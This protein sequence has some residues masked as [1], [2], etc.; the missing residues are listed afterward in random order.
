MTY[1]RKIKKGKKKSKKNKSKKIY[2]HGR[3]SNLNKAAAAVTPPPTDIQVIEPHH[4]AITDESLCSNNI[5]QCLLF[6]I[7]KPEI[8][9]LFHQFDL[10][11]V[12]QHIEP[13]YV[14]SY[15]A[16]A[17][18]LQYIS[19][20]DDSEQRLHVILKLS[21]S[22]SSDN[23][24]YEYYVGMYINQYILPYLPVFIET[25]ELLRFIPNGYDILFQ[26]YSRQ[27]NT[28][29]EPLNMI[30][31]VEP[32]KVNF[33]EDPPVEPLN[34][35][36]TNHALLLQDIYE[37]YSFK[38]MNLMKFNAGDI[39]YFQ[40]DIP[41][42]LFQL[43]YSLDLLLRHP[44]IQFVHKDLHVENIMIYELAEYIEYHFECGAEIVQFKSKYV[45][46][47]IDYG[48]CYIADHRF[49]EYNF[50]PNGRENGFFTDESKCIRYD[51]PNKSIDLR[52]IN[53]LNNYRKRN[54]LKE[55]NPRSKVV[56]YFTEEMLSLFELTHFDGGCK[57]IS[58][59]SDP[60][61]PDI[62]NI[63]DAFLWL[64][65]YL[66]SPKYRD[67]QSKITVEPTVHIDISDDLTTPMAV[68][69]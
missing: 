44:T 8:K 21:R 45:V 38:D 63:H 15:N 31:T 39:D 59:V 3:F 66:T 35:P 53:Q 50:G 42:I 40:I 23:L 11:H 48:R 2:G 5:D 43:Y 19:P 47:I 46:K 54:F 13:I 37:S 61:R 1:K 56:N 32:H 26:I 60:S 55:M 69:F 25:Y 58:R 17:V 34:E 18:H 28:L 62:V 29:S 22:P 30:L 49:H 57:T 7:K 16:Y 52:I 64:K 4:L 41:S 67:L 6:N 9:D 36:S 12:D 10:S 68:R 65:R 33:S 24:Q 14:E 51:T 20:C 27:S